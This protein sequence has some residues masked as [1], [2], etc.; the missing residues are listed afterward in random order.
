MVPQISSKSNVN[1]T[2]IGR[3]A[4]LVNMAGKGEISRE[5]SEMLDYINN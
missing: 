3:I 4:E 2:L 1:Y 5:L